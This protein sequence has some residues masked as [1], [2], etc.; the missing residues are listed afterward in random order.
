VEGPAVSSLQISFATLFSLI[1]LITLFFLENLIPP[2]PN[3]RANPF[4]V[5]SPLV[6]S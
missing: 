6:D 5:H 2:N 4:L 3:C 1:S